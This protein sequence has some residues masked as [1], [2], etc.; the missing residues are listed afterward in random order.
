M[1]VDGVYIKGK[2][3][4]SRH[5]WTLGKISFTVS[6]CLNCNIYDATI[7]ENPTNILLTPM[8]SR[9]NILMMESINTMESSIQV[10]VFLLTHSEEDQCVLNSRRD[11]HYK[12]VC[13]WTGEMTLEARECDT[14]AGLVPTQQLTTVCK[15]SY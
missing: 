8:S 4:R 15:S 10:Y 9:P 5:V 7:T 1:E 11:L 6:Q 12:W 13:L 3:A 14:L 2:L